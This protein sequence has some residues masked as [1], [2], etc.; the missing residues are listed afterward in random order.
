MVD[1]TY[2]MWLGQGCRYFLDFSCWLYVDGD[3]TRTLVRGSQIDKP[4]RILF[5]ES[6]NALVHNS[7]Y[8][9]LWEYYFCFYY[10][11][12]EVNFNVPRFLIY[13]FNA[14]ESWIYN[15]VSPCR[16]EIKH[17]QLIPAHVVFIGRYR[18]LVSSLRFV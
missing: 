15:T 10:T 9:V 13:I 11:P 3:L 18:T 12:G 8:M 5:S 17:F 4:F 1:N 7:P 6:E 2:E 14:L 16:D